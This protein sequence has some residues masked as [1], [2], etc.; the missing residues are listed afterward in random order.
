MV[1]R[2]RISDTSVL[3]NFY[4]VV[5]SLSTKLELRQK[6]SPESNHDTPD[7]NGVC[8][9]GLHAVRPKNRL[10]G[11]ANTPVWCQFFDFLLNRQNLCSSFLE[12]FSKIKYYGGEYS[13]QCHTKC[14]IFRSKN[15]FLSLI[16][17]VLE[18]IGDEAFR[19]FESFT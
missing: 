18:K 17:G 15:S 7:C 8:F 12:K 6:I 3:L 14:R 19:G 9:I 1:L 4:F 10:F 11:L 5:K 13:H 16:S 2:W